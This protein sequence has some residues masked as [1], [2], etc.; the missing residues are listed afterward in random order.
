MKLPKVDR[1]KIIIIEVDPS[2]G[3]VLNK[4]GTFYVNEGDNYYKVFDTETQVED[5][6]NSEK[7]GK[8]YEILLYD[9]K[10]KLIK[11]KKNEE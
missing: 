5:Y 3:T 2:T 9:Y 8:S 10:G 4:D 11:M 7:I 6:I 1:G